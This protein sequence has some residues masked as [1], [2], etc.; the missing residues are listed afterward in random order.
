M[1]AAAE[2]KRI[3]IRGGILAETRELRRSLRDAID[4]A[5]PAD[6]RIPPH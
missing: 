1:V 4:R 3:C 5:I 2:G 6:E